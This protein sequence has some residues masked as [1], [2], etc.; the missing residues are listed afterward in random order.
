MEQRIQ[1]LEALQS[2]E[3]F[4]KMQW[5]WESVFPRQKSELC[6]DL[7]LTPGNTK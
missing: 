5:F 4:A 1:M 7:T 3:F 6:S 2:W